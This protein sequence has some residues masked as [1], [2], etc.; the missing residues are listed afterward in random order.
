[1]KNMLA[2]VI[3]IALAQHCF[4]AAPE[5]DHII[6]Q[7]LADGQ[8]SGLEDGSISRIILTFKQ[9]IALDTNPGSEPPVIISSGILTANVY[10]P[11]LSPDNKQLILSYSS[12]NAISGISC[13]ASTN[14]NTKAVDI[15][16]LSDPITPATFSNIPIPDTIG[17]AITTATLLHRDKSD[18]NGRCIEL[19]F[20]EPVKNNTLDTTDFTITING[21][22]YPVASLEDDGG[23]SSSTIWLYNDSLPTALGSGG[24]VALAADAA[25]HL[26]S[27]D[28]K[29]GPAFISATATSKTSITLV[30]SENVDSATVIAE[31][32]TLGPSDPSIS[33]ATVDPNDQTKI[34]LT[35]G[36]ELAANFSGTCSLD[37]TG[38]IS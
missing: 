3:L 28:D 37:E 18:T 9:E 6:M 8:V 1:M 33:I 20:S 12:E 15:K 29:L 30:C 7:D 11:S 19:T 24:T 26:A 25:A 38:E 35:T 16:L 22:T 36:S 10:T 21:Q 2:L 5:L 4:A 13:R 31:D 14:T 34:Y 32:F 27:L 23:G 17:P